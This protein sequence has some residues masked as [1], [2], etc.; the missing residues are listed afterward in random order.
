MSNH[1]LK[2]LF[3]V[4]FQILF[5]LDVSKSKQFTQDPNL[6]P[7]LFLENFADCLVEFVHLVS[8]RHS[9]PM[10]SSTFQAY[11]NQTAS[12]L[13][14]LSK[15]VTKRTDLDFKYKT[16]TIVSSINFRRFVPCYVLLYTVQVNLD[17]T[18]TEDE[19]AGAIKAHSVSINAD[20]VIF[21]ETSASHSLWRMIQLHLPL[22]DITSS[23]FLVSLLS[24]RV[25]TICVY[26]HPA[27]QLSPLSEILKHS[28][29]HLNNKVLS[30]IWFRVQKTQLN[31]VVFNV[32]LFNQVMP[33]SVLLLFLALF[34]SSFNG[35][36]PVEYRV[37]GEIVQKLNLS[38]QLDFNSTRHQMYGLIDP[39]DES[40]INLPSVFGHD[41]E[42][43]EIN[44]LFF[45]HNLSL[46]RYVWFPWAETYDGFGYTV[47]VRKSS[48]HL[49]LTLLEP[50]DSTT[51][52]LTAISVLIFA[53]ALGLIATFKRK[54]DFEFSIFIDVY[55]WAFAV[56][57]E[58]TNHEFETRMR[59]YGPVFSGLILIWCT[60][61]FILTNAYSGVIYSFIISNPIPQF[62][63]NIRDLVLRSDMYLG[64]ISENLG[65]GESGENG[66]LL[67]HAT[68]EGILRTNIQLTPIQIHLYES[69]YKKLNFL[70]NAAT[71]YDIAYQISLHSCY[72]KYHL[73][74]KCDV[75]HIIP[76]NF[77]LVD[78]ENA[79]STFT[80][81]MKVMGEYL[82]ISNTDQSFLS[83]RMHFYASRNFLGSVFEPILASLY[84]TGI[85][86]RW[87]K[88]HHEEY[89]D[90]LVGRLR[91][92]ISSRHTLSGS[93]KSRENPTEVSNGN[94]ES[95]DISLNMHHLKTAFQILGISN[96]I[97]LL[98]CI[99][100]NYNELIS[101]LRDLGKCFEWSIGWLKV[102]YNGLT[103]NY[104]FGFP[105]INFS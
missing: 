82:I 9:L 23:I 49:Q 65:S 102:T 88:L 105:V 40:Y 47:F 44:S 92:E 12:L 43:S 63:Q 94:F 34:Q 2:F 93:G 72:S 31:L 69:L 33:S 73:R 20:F 14:M 101:A 27:P 53:C 77:A 6:Q 16:K 22:F 39:E 66:S 98:Y 54:W 70:Q 95:D 59:R 15:T 57:L 60:V 79:I 29:V 85:S 76:E 67:K 4:I 5:K 26:C 71:L 19:V 86:S 32:Q 104:N 97:A 51:W 11:E 78:N 13:Q 50:F 62:P 75:D 52:T 37:I 36:S 100:E 17:Q 21:I 45:S 58:Q 64:C 56:L 35:R 7:I 30:N 42:N 3:I 96:I 25:F 83:Y 84:E 103:S 1:R 61:G 8:L 46:K 68:L 90:N 74:E 99:G 91:K 10:N 28:E 81:L 24:G 41:F 18:V 89:K 55:F 38:T 80:E 87:D 48:L